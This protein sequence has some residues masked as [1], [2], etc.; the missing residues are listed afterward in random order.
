MCH[1]ERLSLCAQED[2]SGGGGLSLTKT[3]LRKIIK[4]GKCLKWPNLFRDCLSHRDWSAGYTGDRTR[5]EQGRSQKA[6]HPHWGIW[7]LSYGTLFQYLDL[8]KGKITVNRDMGPGPVWETNISLERTRFF[9]N[10]TQQEHVTVLKVSIPKKQGVL[11]NS[12]SIVRKEQ[13]V[14]FLQKFSVIVLR[15]TIM[16]SEEPQKCFKLIHLINDLQHFP[17]WGWEELQLGDTLVSQC[18][19][20]W[21]GQRR[22]QCRKAED[23]A[24]EWYTASQDRSRMSREFYGLCDQGGFFFNFL[25][26]DRERGRKLP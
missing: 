16:L 3:R 1:W 7:L 11:V 2:W 20:P 24:G 14:N 9:I 10:D 6:S 12:F 13:N 4:G 26:T 22:I 17:L 5:T 25:P 23:G 8:F 18:H 19:L 21:M 15:D